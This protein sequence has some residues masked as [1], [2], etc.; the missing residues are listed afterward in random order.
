[1]TITLTRK[2]STELWAKANC[3]SLQQEP[4]EILCEL[5]KQLAKGYIR[6]IDVHPDLWLTIWDCEYHDDVRYKIPE[7]DHP[8]QLILRLPFKQSHR[9]IR[10]AV[11]GRIYLYFW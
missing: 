7:S 1:M 4:F 5:P 6:D 10:G 8:L 3:N 2:E 9:R 11:R